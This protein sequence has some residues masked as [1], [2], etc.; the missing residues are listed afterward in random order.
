LAHFLSGFEFDS[1]TGWD[2]DLV[3]WCVWVAAYAGFGEF[4]LEDSEISELDVFAISDGID[5]GFECFLDDIHDVILVEASGFTDLGNDLAF[6]DF[7]HFL[8][9]LR[10]FGG[11]GEA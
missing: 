1:G 6:G 2:D 8:G 4:D 7:G 5:D 3:F 11:C 9:G 10:C